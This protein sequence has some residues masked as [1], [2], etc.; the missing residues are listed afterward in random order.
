MSVL[1]VK[2]YWWPKNC[3][4]RIHMKHEQLG[5]DILL[6]TKLNITQNNLKARQKSI[7]A[8]VSISKNAFGHRIHKFSV[9]EKGSAAVEQ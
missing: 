6:G 2:E 9:K 8:L 4:N 1:I 3:H 5:C 7:A